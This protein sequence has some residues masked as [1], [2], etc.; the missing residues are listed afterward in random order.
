MFAA[1]YYGRLNVFAESMT[2]SFTEC[3]RYYSMDS[4]NGRPTVG[5]SGAIREVRRFLSTYSDG[6]RFVKVV[7]VDVQTDGDKR[8][9]KNFG[10]DDGRSDDDYVDH[11]DDQHLAVFVHSNLTDPKRPSLPFVQTFRV[12]WLLTADRGDLFEIVVT[13]VETIGDAVQPPPQQYRLQHRHRLP[14]DNHNGN[15]I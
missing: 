4:L 3:S 10:S 2:D 6:R 14:D 5:R 12:R 1:D 9:E 7:S 15:V 13:V 8:A 11:D